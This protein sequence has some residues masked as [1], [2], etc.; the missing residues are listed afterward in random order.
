M[1]YEFFVCLVDF[2]SQI[3]LFRGFFR[4]CIFNQTRRYYTAEN[5]KVNVLVNFLRG[6]FENSH[7]ESRHIVL[8]LSVI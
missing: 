8:C 4:S 6:F 2:F 3:I 7:A 5:S 1:G